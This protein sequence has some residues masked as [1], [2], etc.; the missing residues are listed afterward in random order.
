MGIEHSG[1]LRLEHFDA[2]SSLY[3]IRL[4]VVPWVGFGVG[5]SLIC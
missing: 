1:V 4:L 5:L 2:R 3:I